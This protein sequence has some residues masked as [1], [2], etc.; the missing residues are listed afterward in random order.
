MAEETG[1]AWENVPVDFQK[2]EHKSEEYLKLNPNGKVPVMVDDAFVL[3]ESL[4]INAY[5]GEKY[6]PEMLGST[7][8]QHALVNQWN[9]WNISNLAHPVEVLAIQKWRKTPDNDQ[10]TT[11]RQSLDRFLPILENA[12]VGKEYLVGDTF[13]TAD[14][15][16]VSNV[17]ALMFIGFDMT[18]L[19]NI[20]RWFGTISQRPAFQKTLGKR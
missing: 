18:A 17:S 11:S 2:S 4:A 19:P 15:N 5:L 7:L 10:T 9:F 3:W 1:Q 6:K 20:Q 12:L 14:L 13:T 8:E 16:L